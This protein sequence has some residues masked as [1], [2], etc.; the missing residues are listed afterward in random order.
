MK[1]IYPYLI[2]V[3]MILALA[4]AAAFF[5]KSRPHWAWLDF[6][7]GKVDVIKSAGPAE[8][9][10]IKKK[11]YRDDIVKTGIKSMA[12]IQ[13]GGDSLV[14][15]FEH[16]EF[17]MASVPRKLSSS[18]DTTVLELLKGGAAFYIEKIR[19]SGIF[20]VKTPTIAI[21]VRGTVFYAFEGPGEC[22]VVVK[23]GS[24]AVKSARGE[25]E[26]FIIE[27]GMR[28]D[29]E[30]KKVRVSKMQK[31]DA[32]FFREIG[33]LRPVAGI[34]CA[35]PEYVERF[36]LWRLNLK[37]EPRREGKEV[38]E[39][40]DAG[41][42]MDDAVHGPVVKG[43]L[44]ITL[45][46]ANG[47]EAAVTREISEKLY[48]R[49]GALRGADKVIYRERGLDKKSVN[50]L[51]TGRVSRLGGSRVVAVNIVDAERGHVLFNKTAV[52]REGDDLD[53]Q[54]DAIA[55]DITSKSGQWE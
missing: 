48:S 14:Q 28:A 44:G 53:A 26:E 49:L 41:L 15:I 17:R 13:C 19:E 27:A 1:K 24:V 21:G 23:E 5:V 43:R 33:E 50:R 29:I 52:I 11:L 46:A 16:T 6:F 2:A 37:P 9:A 3:I 20:T 34:N 42:K 32:A 25:F 30:G 7:L 36:F 54:I 4:A 10:E 8:P 18:E 31:D 39:K 45:L 47:V 38:T 22:T 51:L 55:R 40:G 35:P 12:F